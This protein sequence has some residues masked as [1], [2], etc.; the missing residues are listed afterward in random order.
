MEKLKQKKEYVAK[1][2]KTA[3]FVAVVAAV[4][5]VAVCVALFVAHVRFA[6]WDK[7]VVCVVSLLSVAVCVTGWGVSVYYGN[8]AKYLAKLSTNIV[9]EKLTFAQTGDSVVKYGMRFS[10]FKF[11]ADNGNTLLLYA[12]DT[13]N[14]V[15]KV[16][17]SYM[18]MH[19]GD[20][21]A[22]ICEV[23]T[24]E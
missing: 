2:Q 5:G 11:V 9:T 1:A 3:R 21:I 24:D 13:D 7:L 14:F 12:L 8:Y 23:T 22:D 16:D 4:I 19:S 17:K 20:F 6:V 18:V 15:P 10:T